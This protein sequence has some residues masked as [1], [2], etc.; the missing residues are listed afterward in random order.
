MRVAA[1]GASRKACLL[2]VVKIYDLDGAYGLPSV[3]KDELAWR[4]F[5]RG[6][7]VELDVELIVPHRLDIGMVLSI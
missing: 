3:K 4:L 5:V 6:G 2:R 1:I 7:I